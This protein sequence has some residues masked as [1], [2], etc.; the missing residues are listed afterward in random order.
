MD[1]TSTYI[2]YKNPLKKEIK[3]IV[4]PKIKILSLFTHPHVVPT[5]SERFIRMWLLL[6]IMKVNGHSPPMLTDLAF[7]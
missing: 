2:M 7:F 6:H 4:Q 1:K 5:C 3:G